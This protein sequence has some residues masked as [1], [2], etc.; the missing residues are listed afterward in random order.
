ML[1]HFIGAF[2]AFFAITN[3]ISNLPVYIALVADDDKAT[4]KK[5]LLEVL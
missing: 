1:T 2:M 4:S 5:L 3:P